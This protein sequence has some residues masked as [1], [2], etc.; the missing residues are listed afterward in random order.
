MT[1][2]DRTIVRIIHFY[3]WIKL[4]NHWLTSERLIISC[5]CKNVLFIRWRTDWKGWKAVQNI[6]WHEFN[7]CNEKTCRRGGQLPVSLLCQSTS[8]T[9]ATL[10]PENICLWERMTLVKY[11]SKISSHFSLSYQSSYQDLIFQE[12]VTS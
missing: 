2:F 1:F 8:H 7:N 11:H 10:L 3:C 6:L 9:L 5:I 12:C 4:N